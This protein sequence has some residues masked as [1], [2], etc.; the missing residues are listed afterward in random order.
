MLDFL[1]T[2]GV[3]IALTL[4]AHLGTLNLEATLKILDF[5]LN[6]TR[7]M[8]WK[9]ATLLGSDLEK[10]H[11]VLENQSKKLC[12]AHC[13]VVGLNWKCADMSDCFILRRRFCWIIKI[14]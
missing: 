6:Q 9:T 4:L 8:G 7:E 13:L 2:P 3:H 1:F 5:F 14:N 11:I 12:I 10:A